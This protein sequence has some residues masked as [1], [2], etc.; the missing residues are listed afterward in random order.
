[1]PPWIRGLFYVRVSNKQLFS[2]SWSPP[3][4]VEA[5][6]LKSHK[7]KIMCVSTNLPSFIPASQA[8]GGASW[9]LVHRHIASMWLT[10]QAQDLILS[11][12]SCLRLAGPTRLKHACQQDLSM[13]ILSLHSVSMSLAAFMLPVVVSKPSKLSLT[14]LTYST[15]RLRSQA[16][17]AEKTSLCPWHLWAYIQAEKFSKIPWKVLKFHEIFFHGKRFVIFSNFTL[18]YPKL[19]TSERGI[20]ESYPKYATTLFHLSEFWGRRSSERLQKSAQIKIKIFTK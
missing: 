10:D 7:H 1:M 15:N 13:W 16:Q 2:T 14:N 17:L 3:P 18:T 11:T 8:L 6:K 9:L 5:T 19:R 12:A 4:A 20:S